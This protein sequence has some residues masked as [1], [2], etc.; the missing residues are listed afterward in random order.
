MPSLELLGLT[1]QYKL[2]IDT[3]HCLT[4]ANALASKGIKTYLQYTRV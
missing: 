1:S 3:F 2:I 4:V